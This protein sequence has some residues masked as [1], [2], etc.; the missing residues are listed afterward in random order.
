MR[1][2]LGRVRLEHEDRVD[3]EGGLV[4]AF[5]QAGNHV[6]VPIEADFGTNDDVGVWFDIQTE[7]QSVDVGLGSVVAEDTFLVVPLETP[8]S[9]QAVADGVDEVLVDVERVTNTVAW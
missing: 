2:S 9:G 8:A 3:A 6:V 1:E 4:V 7:R 5:V